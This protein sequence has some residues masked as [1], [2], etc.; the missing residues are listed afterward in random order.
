MV[1]SFLMPIFIEESTIGFILIWSF[2]ILITIIFII[3]SKVKR[4][5]YILRYL[6]IFSLIGT[7]FGI[8]FV[9]IILFNYGNELKNIANEINIYYQNNN[10]EYDENEIIEILN[11]HSKSYL[12]LHSITEDYYQISSYVHIG[13]I[14][15]ISYDNKNNILMEVV[16]INQSFSYMYYMEKFWNWIY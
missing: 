15:Y 1:F 13:G 5:K 2:C 4:K 12:T 16:I 11:N 3:L 14:L 8:I 6:M 10:K 7:I 9:K